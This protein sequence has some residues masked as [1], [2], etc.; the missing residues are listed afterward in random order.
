VNRP[1][2][3]VCAGR[4]GLRVG[5]DV[6]VIALE[7]GRRVDDDHVE[8]RRR[9]PRRPAVVARP[10]HDRQ[11]RVLRT[12]AGT[13]GNAFGATN[14]HRQSPGRPPDPEPIGRAGTGVG[15]LVGDASVRSVVGVDRFADGDEQ[16][17]GTGRRYGGRRHVDRVVHR[18]GKDEC[19]TVIVDVIDV[20]SDHRDVRP[21]PHLRQ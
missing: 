15:D 21:R 2:F 6:P 16:V 17:P 14:A 12:A 10:H 7:D 13:T 11:R 18:V 4:A 8:R 3:R 5:P 1:V 9:R 19:R 20:D